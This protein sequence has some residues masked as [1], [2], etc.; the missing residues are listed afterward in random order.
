[1][2]FIFVVFRSAAFFYTA[3]ASLGSTLHSASHSYNP[4]KFTQHS[5]WFH[6]GKEIIMEITT[7]SGGFVKVKNVFSAV[8]TGR[9]RSFFAGY[10]RTNIPK[11]RTF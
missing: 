6:R 7:Y 10:P 1:M 4:I 2:I 8:H 3:I 5:C 11:L 9:R